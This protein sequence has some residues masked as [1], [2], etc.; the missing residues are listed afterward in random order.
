MASGR[1]RVATDAS[2]SIVGAECVV[3][4]DGKA[5][6]GQSAFTATVGQV[7]EIAEPSGG[8]RCYLC[9]PGGFSSAT[10]SFAFSPH[11]IGARM[12]RKLPDLPGTL[13]PQALRVIT[14]EGASLDNVGELRVTLDS[15]RMGLRLD[16][17][18]LDPG[19]QRLSEPA[20]PGTIQVSNDGRLI[21]LGPDGPTIGG[22]RK[23]GVVCSADLDALGQLRPGWIVRFQA[24]TPEEAISQV[25]LRQKAIEAKLS[26][27]RLDAQ[28]S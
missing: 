14:A 2:L 27:L 12:G 1:F 5:L 19:P 20:C 24:I 26:Q 6:T 16:G 21:I 23:L 15:N 25:R 9:V 10:K 17:V 4:L 8:A 22:Y 13:A 3:Q 28:L 11:D 7:L 18:R